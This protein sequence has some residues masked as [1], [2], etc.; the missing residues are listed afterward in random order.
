MLAAIL[1]AAI[2]TLTVGASAVGAAVVARHRAQSG[3]DLAALA[4]AARVQDGQRVA[5]LRAADVAAAAGAALLVCSLD[6]LDVTVAVGV[7]TGL[8]IGGQARASARAGPLTGD[9][10]N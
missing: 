8:R 7:G 9:G 3:A 2:V 5:C 10:P 1:V 6:G 4:A